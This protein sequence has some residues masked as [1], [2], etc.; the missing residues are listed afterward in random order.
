MPTTEVIVQTYTQ[1]PTGLPK[2]RFE[3]VWHFLDVAGF[4]PITVATTAFYKLAD[5]FARPPIGGGVA[6]VARFLAHSQD[7]TIH[8]IAYDA[9][10]AKPRPEI[11][12]ATLT[13]TPLTAQRVPESTALCLSYYTDRNL[14]SKRGRLYLGPFNINA[15]SGGADASRPDDGLIASMVAGGA[16]LIAIGGV[17]GHG[18]GVFT[19]SRPDLE[20]SGSTAWALFSPKL[21]TY[22]AVQHGWVDDEWDVQRRRRVEPTGRSTW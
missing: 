6:S 22:A 20:Q 1:S 11:A 10:A 15:L 17:V 12:T 18:D 19:P 7:D 21:G 9:A 4:D 3:N 16:R 8:M 5:Y 2:D 14:V 13:Y